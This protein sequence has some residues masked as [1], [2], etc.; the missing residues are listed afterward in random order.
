MMNFSVIAGDIVYVCGGRKGTAVEI[1]D[2]IVVVDLGE[3]KVPVRRRGR[4]YQSPNQ[5]FWVSED[6]EKSIIVFE[7][8][9]DDDAEPS[10]IVWN[11]WDEETYMDCYGIPHMSEK[12]RNFLCGCYE[13]EIEFVS[14]NGDGDECEL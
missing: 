14:I 6:S 2:E 5:R 4:L 10:L 8:Y 12:A 9:I 11:N 3:K 7:C 13:H 1:L